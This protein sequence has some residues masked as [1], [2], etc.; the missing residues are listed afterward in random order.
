MLL[1]SLH[2]KKPK[3]I[4]LLSKETNFNFNNLF[5]TKPLDPIIILMKDDKQKGIKL[6]LFQFQGIKNKKREEI[7]TESKADSRG[8]DPMMSPLLVS[9]PNRRA[10]WMSPIWCSII[11]GASILSRFLRFVSKLQKEK[12]WRH[13]IIECAKRKGKRKRKRKFVVTKRRRRLYHLRI[14]WVQLPC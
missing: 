1:I 8:W 4:T 12:V 14:L 13:F 3:I 2:L 9:R 6:I 11:F 10:S 5:Q 7:I